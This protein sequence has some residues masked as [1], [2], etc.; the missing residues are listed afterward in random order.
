MCG[1][2]VSLAGGGLGGV[3]TSSKVGVNGISRAEVGASK[4]SGS[5]V[6]LFRM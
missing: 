5:I 2:A 4:C 6:V 3:V 1:G